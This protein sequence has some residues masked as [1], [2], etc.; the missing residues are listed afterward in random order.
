[1]IG[2]MRHNLA[3]AGKAEAI[4]RARVPRVAE[5][6]DRSWEFFYLVLA[7]LLFAMIFIFAVRFGLRMEMLA[8][9]FAPAFL[10]LNWWS[11]RKSRL[12]KV[13]RRNEFFEAAS[14]LEN[15]NG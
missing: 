15:S 11:A 3:N 5:A 14:K 13:E 1:M 6:T 10:L 12:K 4:N 9:P 7:L 8:F 2:L